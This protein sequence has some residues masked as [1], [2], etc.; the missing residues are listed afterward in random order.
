M[1]LPCGAVINTLSGESGCQLWRAVI[2]QK[3]ESASLTVFYG[4]TQKRNNIL[5]TV[6]DYR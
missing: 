4:L 6:V 1:S 3:G 5:L 2:E